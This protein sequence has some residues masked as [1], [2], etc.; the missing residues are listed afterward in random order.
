MTCQGGKVR[1]ADIADLT[2]RDEVVK[3][4]ER[5]LD[6]RLAVPLMELVKVDPVRPKPL[7]A[8]LAFGDE[9]DARIA[10][11]VGAAQD[12]EACLCGEHD[13]VALALDRLADDLLGLAARIDIGGVDKV[14][15]GIEAHV[16]LAPG[17]WK[18]DRSERLR[19]VVS[20]EGHRAQ[21]QRRDLQ[22]R[23]TEQAVFHCRPPLMLSDAAGLLL[24]HCPSE[25][26]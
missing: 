5:L 10:A 23:S 4:A 12:V 16:D 19:R 26:T 21:G 17:C 24:D 22:A 3:D 1:A 2:G 25:Q 7:Q 11:V 18:I 8:A 14:D 13:A 9:T 15:A 20:P 6:R